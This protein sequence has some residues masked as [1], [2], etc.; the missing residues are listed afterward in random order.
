LNID[1]AKKQSSEMVINS[2]YQKQLQV[3]SDDYLYFHSRNNIVVLRHIEIFEKYKKYI[4]GDILDWGCRHSV[5]GCLA[6]LYL[7]DN[8]TVHGCDVDQTIK[9]PVFY[10]FI[11]LNYS[12]IN[13]PY[14]LPYK[15]NLFD[16]VIG[17]GVLEHVQNDYESL[18]ELNRVLKTSGYLIITFLPNQYSHAEFLAKAIFSRGHKRKY[19][20]KEIKKQLMHVGFE[21]V[22][23]GYHQ[24]MPTF[25]G[26]SKLGEKQAFIKIIEKLYKLNSIFENLWLINKL[27]ANLYVVCKKVDHF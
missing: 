8:C 7:N 13:H 27:S 2:L 23:W 20:L 14:K 18:K 9:Y 26:G 25:S 5:D 21:P 15:D 4:S 24:F 16:T 6:K 19:R 11:N 17:S 1:A 3:I 10:D 12:P 22:D